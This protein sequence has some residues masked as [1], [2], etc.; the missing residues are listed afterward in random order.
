MYISCL[1]FITRHLLLFR[2]KFQVDAWDPGTICWHRERHVPE[3]KIASEMSV[4]EKERVGKTLSINA[5]KDGTYLMIS[6]APPW[7]PQKLNS[8]TGFT[9][10]PLTEIS[11]ASTSSKPK[12][13][14]DLPNG[15]VARTKVNVLEEFP[16][17]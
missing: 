8:G 11:I 16:S 5:S 7:R 14:L 10:P 3:L 4:S 9:E 12:M 6:Q 15:F 13:F 2:R 17:G 1:L